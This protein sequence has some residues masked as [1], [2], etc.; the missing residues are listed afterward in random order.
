MNVSLAQFCF[1][2][3]DITV[4]PQIQFEKSPEKSK[5]L[6][7]AYI[8]LYNLALVRLSN[9]TSCHSLSRLLGSNNN[10][11]HVALPTYLMLHLPHPLAH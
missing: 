2:S 9:S 11:L 8:S 10:D 5:L 1:L 4:L 6:S 7:I 3:Q